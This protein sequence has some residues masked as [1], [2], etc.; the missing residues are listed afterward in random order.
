MEPVSSPAVIPA[1]F[2]FII[3]SA[4]SGL[5]QWTLATNYASA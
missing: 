4:I 1:F 3:D 2:F 5:Y